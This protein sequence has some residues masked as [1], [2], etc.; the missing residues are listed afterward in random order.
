MSSDYII[1]VSES[2]FQFEVI[3]Y[4]RQKP[5][6][7]DFWAEWCGPC[8]IL[9]PLLEALVEEADGRFRL[10]KVNVDDNPNLATRYNIRGIP[11][12]KGFRGGQIVSE[13][14]GALP[15]PKIEAFLK[16]LAPGPNDLLLSKG[17]SLLTEH[18]W[19]EAEECFRRVL[20]SERSSPA[21]LLG[22]SKSLLAQNKAQEALDILKKFPG[23]KEYAK[24]E[25]LRPLA[26]ALAHTQPLPDNEILEA[27]F[28]RA[29]NLIK[30]GNFPA[31]LDGLLDILRADKRY[32]NGEVQKLVL[33][34][35]EIL[36]DESSVTVNYRRELA[37]ILF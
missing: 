37:S 21:A 16:E 32:R 9:G 12:V 1:E 19:A 25:T 34:I 28:L 33:A 14:V 5:V 2:D 31:A 26:A 30:R 27:T 18:R 3:Q 4:S 7:V 10:A 13:F 17:Q 22:L 8:R 23:S 11:A 29:L 6:V 20:N 36:G 24:A 35:F 15:R